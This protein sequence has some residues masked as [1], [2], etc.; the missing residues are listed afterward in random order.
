MWGSNLLYIWPLCWSHVASMLMANIFS[1][2]F[3]FVP[4]IIK[5]RI[6]PWKPPKSLHFQV[7]H[8]QKIVLKR[9]LVAENQGQQLQSS[10]VADKL[11]IDGNYRTS[12]LDSDQ[13]TKEQP[14]MLCR[15][16]KLWI[17]VLKTYPIST[18]VD[19]NGLLRYGIKHQREKKHLLVFHTEDLQ[20]LC[21]F[22]FFEAQQQTEPDKLLAAPLFLE[23]PEAGST[24]ANSEH[25]HTNFFLHATLIEWMH[26]NLR[27]GGHLCNPPIQ[28]F[29]EII[30]W[31]SRRCPVEI[32]V[33]AVC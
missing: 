9:L 1:E 2:F 28:P 29:H 5:G 4:K 10:L 8:K 26:C 12:R 27:N 30:F 21:V 25:S 15:T 33:I 18:Q 23:S 16:R 24:V 17:Y 11:M 6:C 19:A 32:H 3:F 7:F 14:T 20:P 13:L 22:F 31:C